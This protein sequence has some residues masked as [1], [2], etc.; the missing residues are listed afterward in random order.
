MVME[1]TKN[2]NEH[3]AEV[4]KQGVQKIADV[5]YRVLWNEGRREWNIF[6]NCVITGTPARK[7]RTSA[8]A[9]AIRDARAELETSAAVIVVTC[10]QGR[11][12]ETVWRGPFP[13]QQRI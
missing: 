5:E 13:S 4:R 8:V 11:K 7:K 6:R 3:F 1:M 2:S 12:L 10:L 9:S